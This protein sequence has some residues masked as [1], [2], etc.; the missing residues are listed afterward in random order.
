[1]RFDRILLISRNEK[2]INPII[3][4]LKEYD[5]CS[6]TDY[7]YSSSEGRRLVLEQNFDLVIIKTPLPEEMGTSLAMMITEQ[8]DSSV[9]LI[10][11]NNLR[12]NIENNLGDYGILVLGDPIIREAFR[13]ALTLSYSIH[14]RLCIMRKE[15]DKLRKKLDETKMVNKAKWLLVSKLQMSETDAHRYI[16]KTAMNRRCSKLEVAQKILF[17]YR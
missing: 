2:S 16:E 1:M 5:F 8:T 11:E 3:S 15:N 9:I 6:K 14:Q 12:V 4:L 13:Q 10:L 17:S 7:A